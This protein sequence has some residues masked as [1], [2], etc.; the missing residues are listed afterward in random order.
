MATRGWFDW[1][2]VTVKRLVIMTTFLFSHLTQLS[3]LLP[4]GTSSGSYF[5]EVLAKKRKSVKRKTQAST[6]GCPPAQSKALKVGVSSSPLFTIGAGDSSGR[7]AEPP[8]E[9]LPI[10]V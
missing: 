6:E 4:L 5:V 10:S 8:L 2:F 9:V 3:P 7:V 1:G